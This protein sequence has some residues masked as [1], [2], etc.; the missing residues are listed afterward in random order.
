MHCFS[1]ATFDCKLKHYILVVLLKLDLTNLI[2]TKYNLMN[3]A[4][5]IHEGNKHFLQHVF[6]ELTLHLLYTSAVATNH[7]LQYV[8]WL[9]ITKWYSTLVSDTCAFSELYYNLK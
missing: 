5:H 9:N 2:A 6:K 3:S 8:R 4:W 1:S 7:K